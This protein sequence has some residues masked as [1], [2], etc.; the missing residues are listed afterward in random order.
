M[1]GKN[2]GKP[3]KDSKTEDNAVQA[4]ESELE[5]N[6][7]TDESKG[8]P[9]GKPEGKDGKPDNEDNAVQAVADDLSGKSDDDSSKPALD[10]KSDSDSKPALTGKGESDNSKPALD[11]KSDDESEV[12]DVTG[13]GKSDNDEEG[14]V[15]TVSNSSNDSDLSFVAS[16]LFN[17][18][19]IR[20]SIPSYLSETDRSQMINNV[21]ILE[22]NLQVTLSKYHRVAEVTGVTSEPELRR[23]LDELET[24]RAIN[25]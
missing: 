20:D 3:D 4:L 22:D 21:N 5:G 14:A 15:E 24:L 12:S 9:E 23:K 6:S 25:F 18:Q 17:L 7:P 1:F 11:G 16:D 2:S 13:K 10:G 8:K 19:G